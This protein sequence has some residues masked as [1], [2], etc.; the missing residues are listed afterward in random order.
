MPETLEV[1][2]RAL[3]ETLAGLRLSRS[4]HN[5]YSITVP[6]DT[7]PEEILQPAYWKHLAHLLKKDNG[8]DIKIRWKDRSLR[9]M[10]EVF[11]VGRNYVRVKPAQMLWD[12][13]DEFSAAG[14]VA[15]DKTGYQVLYIPGGDLK[16]CVK[17]LSDG[18]RLAEGKEDRAMADA[19]LADYLQKI[20]A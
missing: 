19:W 7:K 11:E 14:S 2:V 12:Y 16:Y 18:E 3:N 15:F 13:H 6:A 17:R 1:P 4:A 20:A 8:C 5:E 9:W 10:V